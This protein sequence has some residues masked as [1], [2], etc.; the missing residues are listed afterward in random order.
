METM[1]CP[2]LALLERTTWF[3]MQT[4][5]PARFDS[6][7]CGF[8]HVSKD[9]KLLAYRNEIRLGSPLL[10]GSR[11]IFGHVSKDILS[12]YGHLKEARLGSFAS[13]VQE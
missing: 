1:L 5:L 6:T 12:H 13:V 8:F 2:F 11:D 7:A 4:D 9:T 10:F 3:T